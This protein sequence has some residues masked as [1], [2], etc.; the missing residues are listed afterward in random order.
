MKIKGS[1]VTAAILALAAG[2]WILS[3]QF[4]DA[5]A[6]QKIDPKYQQKKTA[7]KITRVRAR[8]IQ[9]EEYT[10]IVL[11]TGQTEGSRQIEIRTQVAG[12]VIKIGAKE[13]AWVK[14]GGLLINFDPEDWPARIEEAKARLTQREMEYAAAQKLAR[15]GFQ[16]ATK[17]AAAF[18]DLQAAKAQLKRMRTNYANTTIHFPFDG[19]MNQRHVEI[20]DVLQKGDPIAHLIDLDPL[21]VTAFVSERDYLTLRQGQPATGRLTDGTALTGVIRYVSAAAQTDTRTF[22]VEMEIPNPDYRLAAGVTAELALPLPPIPAHKVSAALFT[23]DS[24]GR[25]GLKTVGA[26]NRVKFVPV[27]IV[28]GTD[29]EVYVTGL[30]AI[31]DIIVV[32]QDFV[33]ADELVE[34]VPESAIGG[35]NS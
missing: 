9:S 18:A 16:A 3:G 15:K 12:R 2:G 19:V 5:P 8:R 30:P 22:K 21:L 6:G 29:R 4:G 17:H 27:R 14:R 34:P 13:G 24:G 25:L 23:L 35:A 26:D 1:L 7:P 33:T 10:S 32:G 28:G 11:V 20:G 31:C